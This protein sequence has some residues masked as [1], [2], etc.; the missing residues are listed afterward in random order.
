VAAARLRNTRSAGGP[1][2][3]RVT[4]AESDGICCAL[5][6]QV[7]RNWPRGILSVPRAQRMS[8]VQRVPERYVDLRLGAPSEPLGQRFSGR[9]HRSCESVEATSRAPWSDFEAYPAECLGAKTCDRWLECRRWAWRQ[10]VI[11]RA[12]LAVL[13]ASAGSWLPPIAR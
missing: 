2:P 3:S 1:M 8:V 6:T 12:R 7:A 9:L 10:G 4:S 5:G 13:E 11:Y